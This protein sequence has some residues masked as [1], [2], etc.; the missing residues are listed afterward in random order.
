MLFGGD[1]W[2]FFG[3]RIAPGDVFRN[4]KMLFD[5]RVRDTAFAGPTIFSRGDTSYF[6]QRGELVA[7]Q[8]ST[9]IRYLAEEAQKRVKEEEKVEPVWSDEDL[10]R[11]EEEKMDYYK[12]FLDLGH[13]KR[14]FVR[15]GEKLRA[16][17]DRAAHHADLHERVAR[18]PVHDLGRVE[19]RH[20]ELVDRARGLAAR[21]DQGLRRRQGRPGAHRRPV[22]GPLARPHDSRSTPS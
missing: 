20:G 17:A 5:Y 16:P 10:A 9:S 18:L 11:V 15:K 7:K 6:N 14:L 22:H 3:P 12:S 1:E 4:D 8:R 21:D 13:E 19:L 2:W